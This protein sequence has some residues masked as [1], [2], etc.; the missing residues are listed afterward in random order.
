MAHK[1]FYHALVYIDFSSQLLVG[2]ECWLSHF[3]F[4]AALLRESWWHKS[5]ELSPESAYQHRQLSWGDS[6][7]QPWDPAFDEL[8]VDLNS[9]TLLIRS[10]LKIFNF[11]IPQMFILFFL[12]PPIFTTEWIYGHHIQLVSTG[13][14]GFFLLFSS[15][16]RSLDNLLSQPVS[17]GG[18]G[19]R[20]YV[21]EVWELK[22]IKPSTKR[23]TGTTQQQHQQQNNG[24]SGKSFVC[25]MKERKRKKFFLLYFHFPVASFSLFW[26]VT[27][28][29]HSRPEFIQ[30]YLS[31]SLLLYKWKKH[32]NF[33]PHWISCCCLSSALFSLFGCL[34]S[35]HHLIISSWQLWQLFLLLCVEN[36]LLFHWFQMV[37]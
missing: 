1:N 31:L 37:Q 9:T 5:A 30:S 15:L 32:G 12:Y 28:R 33:R 6:N 8:E 19:G 13:F 35:R 17:L 20:K 29:P 34:Q 22:S 2:I 23:H 27:F 24:N 14:S 16:F 25:W 21:E 3:F 18:S 10:S 11:S 36:F 26:I 4:C 7:F